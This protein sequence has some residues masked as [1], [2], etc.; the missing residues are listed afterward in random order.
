VGIG[1]SRN[2]DF[3]EQRRARRS[4]VALDCS[5]RERSRSALKGEVR[6][7]SPLGCRIES[8]TMALTGN[9]LWVRLPG[10]ESIFGTVIWSD[11][12]L[13]GV[14]FE[15]ALHPAVAVQ[16]MPDVSAMTVAND[17]FDAPTNV[18]PFSPLLSRREQIVAGIAD[19]GT[20]PLSTRKRQSGNGMLTMIS[21]TVQR[22]SET[23]AELRHADQALTGPMELTV[24][25]KPARVADVS[26][27]GLRVYAELE[28]EIGQELAIDFA[29][30]DCINGRLVWVGGGE[31]GFSLPDNA[32]D[33]ED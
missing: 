15:Q 13:A 25:G 21:R 31:A 33:L 28:A 14:R 11:G 4:A 12:H 3:V 24:A 20:S 27:S 2:S 19:T 10:L 30:F 23:R 1:F 9:Q 8:P 29:G 17:S 32:L 26:S 22:R 5:V 6:D 7:L 16:Y 18:I